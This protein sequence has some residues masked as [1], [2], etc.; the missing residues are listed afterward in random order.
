MDVYATINPSGTPGGGLFHDKFCE[1]CV[2][3][4]KDC[5]KNNYSAVDDIKLEKEVG[6]LSVISD[7]CTHNRSSAL[8]GRI[9]KHH[10]H[11]LVGEEARRLMEE[12]VAK[13]DPFNRNRKEKYSFYDKPK[14]GPY[15]G[16]TEERL[17]K[18][19]TDKKLEFGRKYRDT[20]KYYM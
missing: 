11:D 9:G 5:L 3:A 10:S 19:I 15:D 17:N 2:R 20:D 1:H 7:I 13:L 6:A 14:R 18:F 4:V 8:R 12:K 16:L